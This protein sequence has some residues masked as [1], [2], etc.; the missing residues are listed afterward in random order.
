MSDLDALTNSAADL[1]T[2]LVLDPS[3]FWVN[4]NP[5]QPD[6]IVD[7]QLGQTNAGRALLEADFAMKRTSSKMLD[8]DT[9]F[10]ARYWRAFGKSG[11]SCYT[12]RFWIVPGDV[13]VRE[14]GSSLYI[15]KA[16]LAVK[17]QSMH[18][19]GLAI[20]ATP[21]RRATPATNASKRR[22]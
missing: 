2:W 4:L 19:D 10:G 17:A 12:S 1:R 5:T 20:P 8:P 6:K 22:W 13:Q 21:A 9:S 16:T 18:I 3:K 7:P 14:A 15:L 11:S